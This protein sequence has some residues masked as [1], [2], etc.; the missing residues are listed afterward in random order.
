MDRVLFAFCWLQGLGVDVGEWVRSRRPAQGTVEYGVVLAGVA[1]LALAVVGILSGAVQN[2]ANSAA[3][4][5]SEAAS[6]A[7][8]A[9]H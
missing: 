2:A 1:V 4:A 7:T 8:S 5:V 3:S 6:G 9:K